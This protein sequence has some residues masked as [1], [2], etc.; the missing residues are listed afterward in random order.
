MN[1][2]VNNIKFSYP[3]KEVLKDAGFEAKRGELVAILGPNGTG[4]TTLLKCINQILKPSAGSVIIG[5]EDITKLKGKDLA[6][7]IGYVEQH[8]HRSMNTVFDDVLLGRTPHI[9]CRIH[10]NDIEIVGSVL[11][12]L[13]LSDFS[14]RYLE[15]L[16]G[17]EL[18]KV[19]IARAIAQK[20]QILLMDEPTNHLDL[21]NQV[22]VMQSIRA[23]TLS[24]DITS[25]ISMHDL[26]LALRYAD[27]FILMKEGRIYAAG[28]AGII[29]ESNISQVYA[30]PVV[31]LKHGTRRIVVPA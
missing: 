6:K 8:H 26:N 20:P 29:T 17:G 19:V 12:E 9:G 24:A 3:G 23:I 15:Q 27:R 1:L 31:I 22:D 10:S 11:Q 16:S 13:G 7:R 2:T 5:S 25:V 4:K 14:M 28:D 21:K 30:L 18:Q